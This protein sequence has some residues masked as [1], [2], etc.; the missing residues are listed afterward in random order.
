[1][2]NVVTMWFP[3]GTGFCGVN[4][5]N[6]WR[7]VDADKGG[8]L[9]PL[10]PSEEEALKWAEKQGYKVVNCTKIAKENM[11]QTKKTL[12]SN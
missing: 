2:T 12:F 4:D 7:I 5:P 10:F 1:M 3:Q 9:G 11:K 8:T 6:P